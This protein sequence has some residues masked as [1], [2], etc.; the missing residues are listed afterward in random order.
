MLYAYCKCS[1]FY[2]LFE[3]IWQDI[4]WGQ[5]VLG[6]LIKNVRNKYY[7]SHFLVWTG[8]S[9][10]AI[11]L[12]GKMYMNYIT[13]HVSIHI[14]KLCKLFLSCDNYTFIGKHSIFSTKS[15]ETLKHE[16]SDMIWYCVN[17]LNIAQGLVVK[18]RGGRGTTTK[19]C[20]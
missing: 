15:I 10:L 19:K 9:G 13:E 5:N 3:C 14:T 17:W 4:Q 20:N 7:F 12:R 16:S 8:Q 2:M 18:V 11:D 6:C 1:L